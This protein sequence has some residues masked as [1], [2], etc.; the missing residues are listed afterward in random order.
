VRRG[1]PSERSPAREAR[2]KKATPRAR[3]R[4]TTSSSSPWWHGLA[5]GVLFLVSLTLVN[6]GDS[7]QPVAPSV[8][9]RAAAA[10]IFGSLGLWLSYR[11]ARRFAGPPAALLATITIWLASS[12]PVHMYVRPFSSHA[13]TM[14]AVALFLTVWLRVWESA[15]SRWRWTFVVLAAALV[16]AASPLSREVVNGA[17]SF[18]WA[19]PKLW[20]AAFSRERG[21]FVWTPILLLAVAGL[22]AAVRRRPA[23]GAILIVTAVCVFYIAAAFDRGGETA[24]FG[25]PHVIALAPVFVCGL[26]ALFDAI[27]GSRGRGAW[28]ALSVAAAFVMAWNLGLM[29]QWSTGILPAAGP[30]DLRRAASNQLTAVPSAAGDFVVRYTNDRKALVKSLQSGAR[31]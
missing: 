29:L 25:D 11:L 13:L 3:A 23:F 8:L 31:E 22:I 7:T 18:Q 10:A 5:L 12:L 17:G 9:A 15:G 21:V 24:L 14:F 19:R 27:A 26:A 30:L 4:S 16:I 20:D 6:V 1:L 2:I 28:A